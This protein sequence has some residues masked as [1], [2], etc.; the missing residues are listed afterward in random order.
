MGISVSNY[1][2]LLVKLMYNRVKTHP[3]ICHKLKV[4]PPDFFAQVRNLTFLAIG[5][6]EPFPWKPH[7]Q[8]GF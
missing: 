3:Q 5:G 4:D 1:K 7:A 8:K 2:F 6:S